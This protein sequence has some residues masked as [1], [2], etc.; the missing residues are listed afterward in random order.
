MPYLHIINQNY[1]LQILIK[2]KIT[3]VFKTPSYM[4]FA[5]QIN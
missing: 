4:E 1:A 3:N 5:R 2:I